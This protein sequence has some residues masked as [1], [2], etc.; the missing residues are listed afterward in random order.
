MNTN[1]LIYLVLYVWF[2]D[3]KP[4]EIVVTLQE[5]ITRLKE[6]LRVEELKDVSKTDLSSIG[7][8]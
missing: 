8:E 1:K 7:K 4:S 6:R 3:K 2:P 5:I